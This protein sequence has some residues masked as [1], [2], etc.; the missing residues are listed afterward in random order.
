MSPPDARIHPVDVAVA[1]AAGALRVASGLGRRV[2][3]ALAPVAQRALRPP[4]VPERLQPA[5][6]LQAASRAGE[7]RR[8]RLREDLVRLLDALVPVVVDEVVRRARLTDVVLRYVDLDQVV[9]AV[10]L[11]AA[12]AKVDVGAVVER[13]DLDR[14]VDRVDIDAAA[15]RLDIDAVLDRV[16]LT[17][18][19]LRRVDLHAIVQAVLDR[20]DL[21]G[22][23]AEVID[24][25]DL[26]EIIRESTGSMASDTV[27]GVRMQGI[28]A[29]EAVGRA[30][31]RLLLRHRGNADSST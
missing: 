27:R 9:A 31:D 4:L 1:V 19:V 26:P 28:A 15:A 29:D 24:G 3:P 18:V 16:D 11:D 23:A 5:V 20:L 6:Y 10:D 12:V 8:E 25:V 22:L 21:V 7:E 30:V 13:V 14:A 2:T 17:A